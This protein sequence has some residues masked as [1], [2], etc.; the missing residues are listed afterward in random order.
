M[1]RSMYARI[2]YDDEIHADALAFKKAIC[3]GLARAGSWECQLFALPVAGVLSPGG[4]ARF[5]VQLHFAATP[6]SA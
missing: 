1:S 3:A 4:C 5:A 6:V 2:L